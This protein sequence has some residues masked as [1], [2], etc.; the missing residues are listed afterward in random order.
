MTNTNTK[1][2]AE[3]KAERDELNKAIRAAE[4]AEREAAKRAVLDA[5]H[6]LGEWLAEGIGAT[7]PEAVEAIR[8]SLDLDQIRA[9]LDAPATTAPDPEESSSSTGSVVDSSTAPE[10]DEPD[11]GFGFSTTSHTGYGG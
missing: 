3:L 8:G 4:R 1:T 6:A 11:S 9:A 2:A 10:D 5:Q 7:T